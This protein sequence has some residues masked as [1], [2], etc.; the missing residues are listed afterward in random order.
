MLSIRGE[1]LI[2]HR[3]LNIRYENENSNKSRRINV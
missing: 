2:N 1:V 3:R